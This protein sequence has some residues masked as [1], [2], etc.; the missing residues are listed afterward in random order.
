[1]QPPPSPTRSNPLSAWFLLI[2]VAAVLC[3]SLPLFR[4]QYVAAPIIIGIVCGLLAALWGLFT[5]PR[6]KNALAGLAAGAMV[7]VIAGIL[8]YAPRENFHTPVFAAL[9]GSVMILLVG[10]AGRWSR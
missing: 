6:G 9:A 10:V 1:M 4:A 5:P 3:S 2:A 7:G 8:V